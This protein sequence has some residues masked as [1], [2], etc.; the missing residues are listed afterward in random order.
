MGSHSNFK[1]R[2]PQTFEKFK[3][4]DYKNHPNHQRENLATYDNSILYN[5]SIVYEIIRLFQDKETIAFYFS[6]HAIDA[7]ESSDDYIAHAKVT[8]PKSVEAGTKIPF[9]IYTSPLYQQNFANEMKQIKQSL[10]QPFR[11]DDMIYTIMDIIGITFEEEN[12]NGKS[13][14]QTEY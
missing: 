9:M 1:N 4:E 2:Y 14:F 10:K 12:L 5:D 7:Y 8:V 13:L 11:T 6:D 3:A